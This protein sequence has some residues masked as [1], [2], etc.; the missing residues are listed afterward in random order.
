MKLAWIIFTSVL[1][2]LVAYAVWNKQHI[3]H[4]HLASDA[5]QTYTENS[6]NGGLEEQKDSTIIEKIL[7]KQ[8]AEPKTTKQP[9]E[10]PIILPKPL[11]ADSIVNY[12]LSLKGTPY[13][14]A[15]ITWEGFD[16]SGFIYH[17][18]NKY[19]V[20]LPHSSALLM[21]EGTEVPMAEARKGDLIV[22]TGTSKT[23]T[24]PGHVGV[25]ITE[26]GQPIEFVHSSSAIRNGGV[27]ISK[28]DSTDYARRF[29]QVRRVL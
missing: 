2:L 3:R 20:K 11:L 10:P 5:P 4:E 22:F 26:K 28:V 15:G 13:L 21:K 17:I 25:V 24:E 27:K 16:C 8:P 23:D 14:P 9:S 12:G 7:K 1:V 18:Y 29:L 6:M 19:G